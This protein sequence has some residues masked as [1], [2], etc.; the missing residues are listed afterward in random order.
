MLQYNYVRQLKILFSTQNG[1][2]EFDTSVLQHLK[3]PCPV[4]SKGVCAEV[5]FDAASCIILADTTEQVNKIKSLLKDN[6]FYNLLTKSN[7]IKHLGS[8]IL[9]NHY[10]NAIVCPDLTNQHPLFY[11]IQKSILIVGTTPR[12]VSK[13]VQSRLS[14]TYIAARISNL[15]SFYPFY[16]LTPWE[17]VYQILSTDAVLVQNRIAKVERIYKTPLPNHSVEE[18][19]NDFYKKIS[20]VI[21]ERLKGQTDVLM[22]LSGGLDSTSLC[23]W[24]SDL[25]YK[26]HSLYFDSKL[27]FDSDREWSRIVVQDLKTDHHELDYFNSSTLTKVR[28]SDLYNQLPYGPS[29]AYRYIPVKAQAKRLA[30]KLGVSYYNNGHAGDELFGAVPAMSWSIY[31]SSFAHKY[32]NLYGFA[33]ANRFHLMMFIKALQDNSS[34]VDTLKKFKFTSKKLKDEYA[35]YSARWIENPYKLDYMTQSFIDNI[36]IEIERNIRL[37]HLPID[38]DRTQHQI[39]ESLNEHTML[40]NVLNYSVK[41]SSILKFFAPYI[42][43]EIIELAASMNIYD[44]FHVTTPKPLLYHSRSKNMQVPIFTRKDKG[45]YSHASFVEYDAMKPLLVDMFNSDCVIYDHGLIDKNNI[46]QSLYKFSSDGQS[47]DTLLRIYVIEKW[48]R[49]AIANGDF[50]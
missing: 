19:S 23:Y 15:D 11:T 45:E 42:D 22:D 1:N 43:P 35:A 10:G 27:I 31:H 4:V 40:M 9:Y 20:E 16:E 47:F 13:C 39:F 46:M 33:R 3:Q 37:S 49:E 17:G 30:T 36:E 12:A 34:L 7:H 28:S 50:E 24:A 48:I 38:E 29:E 21:N 8:I 5:T 14:D 2:I 26:I 25:G 44:R 41:G 18:L 32:Q 6:P